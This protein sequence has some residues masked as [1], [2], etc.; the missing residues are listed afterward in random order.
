MRVAIRDMLPTDQLLAILSQLR[1][2]VSRRIDDGSARI[3]T[4]TKMSCR[5]HGSDLIVN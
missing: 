4:D 5:W 3:G 1:I 2:A